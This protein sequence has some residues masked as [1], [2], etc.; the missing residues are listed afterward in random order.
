MVSLLTPPVQHSATVRRQYRFMSLCIGSERV[1]R[2]Q[3]LGG[4]AALSFSV[5]SVRQSVGAL[6]EDR[7]VEGPLSALDFIPTILHS[8]IADGTSRIDLTHYLQAAVDQAALQL[9]HLFIPQGRYCI[10]GEGVVLK[11]NV[12]VIGAGQG[13]TVIAKLN[14]MDAY[15]LVAAKRSGIVI[16]ALSVDG[17]RSQTRS[18]VD[19]RFGIYLTRCTD[20]KIRNVEVRGTLA[21][22]IVIEYG[23][24]CSVVASRVC[25]NSKL[26][27]YF[28]GSTDCTAQKI[29]ADQ[30]GAS[31][32]KIGGG[33]GFAASWNCSASDLI[34]GGN[35]EADVLLSRGSRNVTIENARLGHSPKLRTPKSIMVLGETIAGVLHGV[36]FGDGSRNF[37]ADQC[38]FRNVECHGQVT[39]EFLADSRFEACAFLA[40]VPESVRIFGSKN[41]TFDD[42]R[43]ENYQVSGLG[44]YDSA[45]NGVVP[46]GFV[47]VSNAR[48]ISLRSRAALRIIDYSSKPARVRQ[49]NVWFNGKRA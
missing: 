47:S 36:D 24:R 10:S 41:L 33:I 7:H 20:C 14:D 17:S 43:F 34:C 26:G 8:A 39:L 4:L 12:H 46:T 31:V 1:T 15:V 18:F 37:G 30:N 22:G 5:P 40:D 28:S 35:A 13:R 23:T 9:Q 44:L 21:D 6:R 29:I 49:R 16:E 2:R 25:Y 19:A 45:K 42:V 11:D 27:L 38:L 3:L 48:F 32:T